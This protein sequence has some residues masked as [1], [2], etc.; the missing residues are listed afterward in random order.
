MPN[1]VFYKFLGGGGVKESN[2]ENEGA[3]EWAPSSFPR[4][5]NLP[6]QKGMNTMGEMM[7]TM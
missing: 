4:F 1:S 6:V 3:S 7:C 2:M 5:R